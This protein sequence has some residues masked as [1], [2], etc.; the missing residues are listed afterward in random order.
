MPLMSNVR[1]HRM[2][3]VSERRLGSGSKPW[4]LFSGE[5]TLLSCGPALH[6]STAPSAA[7]PREQVASS[8]HAS[9]A[10]RSAVPAS[11]RRR[12]IESSSSQSHKG[13]SRRRAAPR[14]QFVKPLRGKLSL[15]HNLVLPNT[16]Q[17]IVGMAITW[18]V[19]FTGLRSNPS[20]ERTCNGVTRL[21]LRSSPAAPLHAAH[22]KR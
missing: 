11:A 1:A 9:C 2:P 21:R 10:L 8:S 3:S 14:S 19:P 12:S 15:L 13:A 7:C 18:V 17:V 20:I 4:R 22:V 5:R 16:V 6:P